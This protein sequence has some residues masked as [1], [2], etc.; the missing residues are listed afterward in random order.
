MKMIPVKCL[1]KENEK[2]DKAYDGCKDQV[3]YSD[4]ERKILCK[5]GEVLI[6][7]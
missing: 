6:S 2:C 4:I 3:M 5:D 7:E 1:G